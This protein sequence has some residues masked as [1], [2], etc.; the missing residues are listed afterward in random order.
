MSAAC[1][2]SISFRV[3]SSGCRFKIALVK[4]R[5]WSYISGM[6]TMKLR[7]SKLPSFLKGFIS[8]FDITGQTLL[9]VPDVSTGY[10]RDAQVLRE[11]WE[12]VGNDMRMAMDAY[13]NE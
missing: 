12:Q 10:Q 9:D 2:A 4:K 3:R 7:Y 11:V 5:A 1:T 8:A 13:V 6:E